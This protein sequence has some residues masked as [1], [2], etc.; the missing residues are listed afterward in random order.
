MRKKKGE[1][2]NIS[3]QRERWKISLVSIIHGGGNALLHFIERLLFRPVKQPGSILIFRTGS[4]G[5]GIC[6]IPAIRS[7]RRQFPGAR[8]D[9]LTNTGHAGKS[10]VSLDKILPPGVVDHT[11]NYEG[12]SRLALAKILRRLQYDAVIQLPQYNA[13]W[14]CLLRDMVVFRV[15]CRISAGFGWRWD[16]VPIFLKAQ[17]IGQAA[18]NERRRLL[19]IVAGNGIPP[20][21]QTAFGL[22]ITPEDQTIAG[23][24]LHQFKTPGKPL[25]GLVVGAKRPQNRWPLENFC[26]VCR[27]F[28]NQFDIA[29]LG[30]P[31]DQPL[32]GEL[33]RLEGVFSLC[34][35]LTPLQS[36]W[37]M[38]KCRLVLS[39]DTGPMHLAYAMG[40]P[41]LALFSARD[42]PGRWYPPERE[43]NVVLRSFQ[44]PCSV[45]LSETCDNNICL[46]N[47]HPETVIAAMIQVMQQ[48][49]RAC[50]TG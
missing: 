30:G 6:A 4:L 47:I 24:V 12:A 38:H 22:S 39:N 40:T 9:L 28:S 20:L 36:A 37:V 18:E 16:H 5:D 2:L 33:A 1:G 8:I 44:L 10:L 50:E 3:R 46:K 43:Q 34:G 25:L 23:R 21:R 48:A 26:Q 49:P 29:L 45:C 17:E 32:A 27:H 19:K 35:A 42:L 13:P 41:V 7:I 15:L 11:I 14:Y 31:D